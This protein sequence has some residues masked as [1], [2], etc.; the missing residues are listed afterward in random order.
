MLKCDVDSGTFK[1]FPNPQKYMTD[2]KIHD[3]PDIQ[4]HQV[5]FSGVTDSIIRPFS[6]HF[7]P[8]RS[9]EETEKILKC[10]I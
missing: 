10:A 4:S 3:K 7:I 9:L 8:I 2:L 6:S 1:Y 5:Q